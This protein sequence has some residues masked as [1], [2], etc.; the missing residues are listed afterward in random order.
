[1]K[2]Y[3]DTNVVISTYK[4]DEAFYEMALSISKSDAI[5]KV[6]SHI[7]ILELFSVVSRLYKASQIV[8]PKTVE[9]IL[10]KLSFGDRIL[11]IVNAILLDW[12]IICPNLRLELRELKLKDYDLLIPEVFV[13]ACKIASSISLKTLD[14]LHIAY[15]KIIN[16]IFGDLNYFVTVD[17]NILDNR[18]KI[19]ETAKID[20]ISPKELTN[21]LAP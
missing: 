12:N 17:Q 13:E 15:A 7:L 14:A 4:P 9:R 20:V 2:I 5:R 8:L 11:A 21:L 1:M 6:G 10:S 16:E 18:L 19:K 3:V